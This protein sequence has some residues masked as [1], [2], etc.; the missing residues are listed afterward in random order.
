[1]SSAE[2]AP[3]LLSAVQAR[4]E[5]L[6]AAQRA[7]EASGQRPSGVRASV[8]ASLQGYLEV[9]TGLTRALMQSPLLAAIATE[10]PGVEGPVLGVKPK[11]GPLEIV[12]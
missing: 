4:H 9:A 6:R 1:V 2:A 5:R 7:L 10:G 3:R 11:L 12:S 8:R